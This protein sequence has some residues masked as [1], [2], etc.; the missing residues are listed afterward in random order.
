MRRLSFVFIGLLLS[1]AS[2]AKPTAFDC[3]YPVYSNEAGINKYTNNFMLK[4]NYDARTGKATLQGDGGTAR[5]QAVKH[6]Q[7]NAISFIEITPSG[8]VMT[9]TIDAQTRSVYSRNT[10]IGGKLVATQSYGKCSQR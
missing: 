1:S 3:R 6:K 9:I 7:N 2:Q 8:N 10:T 4:I 5:L